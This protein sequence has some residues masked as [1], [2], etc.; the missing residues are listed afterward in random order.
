MTEC[1]PE[2]I[3][4]CQA[5]LAAKEDGDAL[6]PYLLEFFDETLRALRRD[7]G[8]RESQSPLPITS[9]AAA[10]LGVS[11]QRAGLPVTKVPV[12][13]SA[14]SQALGKTGQ[15][16]DLTIS[17]EE[18]KLL[19]ACLDA[20]LATSIETFWRQE[21]KGESTR[22]TERFGFMAHELRNA[23]GNVSMAF[24]LLRAGGLEMTGRTADVLERNLIRMDALVAQTLASVRLEA[25]GAP[26][27]AP[28]HLASVLRNIE[29]S[30]IPDR[31]ITIVLLLDEQ[32]FAC[33]DEM[34]LTSS[35]SNLVHNAVKFSPPES[36]IEIRAHSSDQFAAIEVADQC[37]G[38]SGHNVD[39]MFE[40]Y[41]KQAE[42]NSTG[43]GLGLWIAKRAVTAMHGDLTFSDRPGQGCVFTV[44]VPLSSR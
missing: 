36:T 27:L 30:T 40:P 8:I 38:L 31:D 19:N 15:Q 12:M 13:F 28:V 10:R 43:T 14:L 23:L 39:R 21:K 26:I 18:Y 17:A 42:G 25:G 35:I 37:G 9:D 6:A 1:R 5:E 32:I 2:I 16:H 11:Q 4:A 34:L 33:A 22:V 7:C 20:G 29:A 3:H 44:L 24:K 41:F